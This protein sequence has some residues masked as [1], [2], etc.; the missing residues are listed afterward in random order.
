MK[1]TMRIMSPLHSSCTCLNHKSIPQLNS[2]HTTHTHATTCMSA[3]T[4]VT[5]H[6]TSPCKPIRPSAKTTSQPSGDTPLTPSRCPWSCGQALWWI[7][8]P[9][10][11]DCFQM[12]APA[13]EN[14][15]MRAKNIRLSGTQ[16]THCMVSTWLNLMHFMRLHLKPVSV[17]YKQFQ[18]S[19]PLLS[20]T[21]KCIIIWF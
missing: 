12:H 20:G 21:G 5:S 13:E 11:S 19:H 7:C 9:C 17:C 3:S 8:P 4:L 10:I 18:I 16:Q 1:T 14:R 6:G 2:K 15:K